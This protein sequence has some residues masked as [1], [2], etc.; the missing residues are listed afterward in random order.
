MIAARS[1]V[2]RDIPAKS[3]AVG[4]PARVV[5]SLEKEKT[6]EFAAVASTLEEALNLD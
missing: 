1:V 3:L 6:L 4:S 2:T 5:R